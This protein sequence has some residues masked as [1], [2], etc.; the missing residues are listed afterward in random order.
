MTES[1]IGQGLRQRA[2]SGDELKNML[3]EATSAYFVSIAIVQDFA[4]FATRAGSGYPYGSKMLRNRYAYLS[5]MP[6]LGWA[7]IVIYIP[8]E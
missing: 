4:L 1:I 6:S 5:F 2:F 8:F 7:M 3:K